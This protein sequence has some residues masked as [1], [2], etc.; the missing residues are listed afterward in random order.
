[1]FVYSFVTITQLLFIS[2]ENFIY[3]FDYIGS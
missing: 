3:L 1:M 2:F